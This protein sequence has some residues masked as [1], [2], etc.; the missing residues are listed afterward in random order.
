MVSAIAAL[1]EGMG[2][3]IS[4]RGLKIWRTQWFKGD[5][6][7]CSCPP[8]SRWSQHPGEDRGARKWGKETKQYKGKSLHAPIWVRQ[9]RKSRRPNIE[10]KDVF[11]AIFWSPCESRLSL[12]MDSFDDGR[13]LSFTYAL[14]PLLMKH[15]LGQTDSWVSPA[16]E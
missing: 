6:T 4:F 3:H 1:S 7:L 2:I 11:H 16:P 9:T 10:I 13:A 8:R 14:L 15:L 12:E 5:R